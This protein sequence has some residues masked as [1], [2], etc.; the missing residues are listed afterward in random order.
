MG[1]S[2][3]NLLSTNVL[4]YQGDL[5]LADNTQNPLTTYLG[6]RDELTGTAFAEVP[7]MEFNMSQTHTL[8]AASQPAV[9]EN[10]TIAAVASSVNKGTQRTNY[11][12]VFTRAV[13]ASMIKLADR[14]I[15]GNAVDGDALLLQVFEPQIAIQQAQIKRDYEFSCIN[16]T[17]QDSNGDPDVAYKMRGI[18]NAVGIAEKAAGGA[19]IGVP[20]FDEIIQLMADAGASFDDIQIHCRMDVKQAIAKLFGLPPRDR[21]LGG[22]NITRIATDAGEMSLVYNPKMAADTIGFFDMSFCKLVSNTPRIAGAVPFGLYE[23]ASVSMAQKR[24]LYGHLGI[25][26][27]D[28]VKHGKITNVKK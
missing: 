3:E 27:G 4:N 9:T 25:D 12:Q 21:T 7:A 8:D 17:A 19:S 28:G 18:L 26:F 16:G 24:Q 6:A 1:F 11:A 22:I 10:Q 2:A 20:L 14:S 13:N 23:I 15:S 5:I